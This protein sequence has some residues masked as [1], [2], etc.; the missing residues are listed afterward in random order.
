MW[1]RVCT[2]LAG[3]IFIL[4]FLIVE[5]II[6]S[7]FFE[8][9]RKDLDYV[10][11]LGAQVKEG[12]PSVVLQYRLDRAYEYLM[13][14]ADT[15]C[16]VSG[17]Q[18]SN[19]LVSEADIMKSYLVDKGIPSYRI[20]VEDRSRNTEE[21]IRFSFEL[22]GDLQADIG[23]ITNNF[24]VFRGSAIARKKG[25]LNVFGISASSNPLYLPN[26]MLREFFAV[27][28]DKLCGNI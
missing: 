9:G 3:L 23:I 22:I 20:L 15:I 7:G 10:I 14:N 21:N 11:V 4:L 6:I 24:H 25:A 13:E 16:I 27:T 19:E 1:L 18:G 2:K 8:H 12:R 17:G 28:K 26:N 5:G